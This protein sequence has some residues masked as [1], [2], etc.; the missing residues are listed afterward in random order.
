M[1][2]LVGFGINTIS[3][4]A[5]IILASYCVFLYIAVILTMRTIRFLPDIPVDDNM[6]KVNKAI[7]KRFA[8]IVG[9]E[10][11]CGL[12]VVAACNIFG[13]YRYI[14][15]AMAIVVGVHF[16]LLSP[17]FHIRWYI[18]QELLWYASP[19]WQCF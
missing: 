13:A 1:L 10:F 2:M 3:V 15:P 9:A 17:L 11:F 18:P 14:A 12:A 4:V 8:I 6:R 7:G 5:F 16:I 19:P